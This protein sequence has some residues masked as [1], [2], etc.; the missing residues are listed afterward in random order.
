MGTPRVMMAFDHVPGAS[1]SDIS[2]YTTTGGNIPTWSGYPL[3]MDPSSFV[4]AGPSTGASFKDTEGTWL[5]VAQG[6]APGWLWTIRGFALP[7]SECMDISTPQSYVCFRIKMAASPVAGNTCSMYTPADGSVFNY[8]SV[9]NTGPTPILSL[10]NTS[11]IGSVFNTQGVSHWVEV[12][13]DRANAFITIWVDNVQITKFAFNPS[14]LATNQNLIFGPSLNYTTVANTSVGSI[15][16][17]KDIYTLDNIGDGTF[18]RLGNIQAIPTSVAAA[19]GTGWI[20]SDS[21]TG[22]TLVSDLN[23]P[24]ISTATQP[25]PVCLAPTDTLEPLAVTLATTVDPSFEIRAVTLLATAVGQLGT[26]GTMSYELGDITLPS[27]TLTDSSVALNTF[28][29]IF[30]TAPDDAVWTPTNIGTTAITATPAL[31]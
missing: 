10:V 5:S 9:G 17:M 28:L 16:Q 29:G 15:L 6:T 24:V 30:T 4:S 31:S 18:A 26:A 7:F 12:L 13:I 20:A 1:T 22:G 14:L 19:V 27:Q 8:L 3:T 25:V 2:E 11:N 23:T 21:S